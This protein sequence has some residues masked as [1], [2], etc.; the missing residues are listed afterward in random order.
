MGLRLLAVSVMLV[1]SGCAAHSSIL[2]SG[3]QPMQ[4]VQ[5]TQR[6][7]LWGLVSS[8]TTWDPRTQCPAGIAKV[9]TSAYVSL[10]GIYSSYNIS[11]WCAAG[12]PTAYGPGR[13]TNIIV[14]PQ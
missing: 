5:K 7:F 2:V 4:R 13:G 11:A 12:Q 6:A 3:A 1:V 8:D 9:E 14:V 10:L